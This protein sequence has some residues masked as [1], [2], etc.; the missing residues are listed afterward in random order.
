M[1][2][3]DDFDDDCDTV[4]EVSTPY[5]VS[6][7]PTFAQ[8]DGGATKSISFCSELFPHIHP[9]PDARVRV[10]DGRELGEDLGEGSLNRKS[11]FPEVK[12]D[13]RDW[14]HIC[15][16]HTRYSAQPDPTRPREHP[17]HHNI[18]ITSTK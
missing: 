11:G 3:Q 6:P 4:N 12:P 7:S 2:G 10:A 15:F 14:R 13:L 16:P 17:A 18:K 1:C 9:S 8:L 5:S